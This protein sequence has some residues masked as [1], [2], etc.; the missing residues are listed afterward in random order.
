M[1]AVMVFSF[2]AVVGEAVVVGH[3]ELTALHLLVMRDC[4]SKEIVSEVAVRVDLHGDKVQNFTLAVLVS[5][6]V[7]KSK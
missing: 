7:R 4:W 5:V 3:A 2:R 1:A 6:Y